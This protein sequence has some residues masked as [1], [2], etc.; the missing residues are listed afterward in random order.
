MR[1]SYLI[2]PAILAAVFLLSAQQEKINTTIVGAGGKP[3]LAVIDFKRDKS[4]ASAP[5]H[6]V[7]NQIAGDRQQPGRELCRRVV[8]GPALP[9]AH[10][11]LLG[12]I[13]GIGLAS[14]HF[15]NCSDHPELVA[16]DKLFEGRFV[17][18][19]DEHH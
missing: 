13:L 5:A 19:P 15:S 10:K 6:F 9:N 1:K 16:H 8:A 18:V 7:E 2:L 11:D 17:S 3:A 12:D 14:K 4:A